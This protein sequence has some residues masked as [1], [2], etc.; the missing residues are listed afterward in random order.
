MSVATRVRGLDGPT[1]VISGVGSALLVATLASFLV[2]PE[3]TGYVALA[4]AA[5]VVAGWLYDQESAAKFLL[6]VTTT[7][8]V[9]ILGLITVYLLIKAVPVA[10]KMGGYLLYGTGEFWNTS[11]DANVYSLVPMMWGT[12]VT[13]A[14]ATVV[15]APLGVAGA[16]F[17]SELAPGWAREMI[18]PA[19]EMLA[20]IPSIVYGFI[21]FQIIN[22]FM[23]NELSM[24][25]YGSLAVAGTVVGLMALPTVVSVAE[26]AIAAVP[27]AMKDGAQALG[28]TD[29]Q[30]TTSVTLPASFS[31]VSAAV[32]LGV[33]RAVG[34]TMAAVVILG[35]VVALPDP[36][37]DVFG[38]T[39]TLTSLI[40][41]QYGNAS[42]LHLSALFAAGVVLFVTVMGLSIGSQLVE[43]RMKRQLGGEV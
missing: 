41:S 29:W 2:R 22:P 42:G 23:M 10:R 33:G 11:T 13:T 6:F 27:D 9:V 35:N 28:A 25:D 17:I 38:N 36:L 1:Q 37:V 34:E 15:A 40:A 21:G 31:G 16:I 5:F 19:V 20:G 32:L 18:K 26:D 14:I 39:I 43:R 3:L 24:P 12:L 4:F 7:S 8:T 30:T